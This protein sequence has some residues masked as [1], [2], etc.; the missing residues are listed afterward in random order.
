MVS[1]DVF[2]G[3]DARFTAFASLP[4]RF[5]ATWPWYLKSLL[6]ILYVYLSS[7][8]VCNELLD[9]WF[10]SIVLACCFLLAFLHH[11]PLL[12]SLLGSFPGLATAIWRMRFDVDLLRFPVFLCD[13]MMHNILYKLLVIIAAVQ[14]FWWLLLLIIKAGEWLDAFLTELTCT[15]RN[16]AISTG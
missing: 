14:L 12:S 1:K 15:Y 5:V 13:W 2:H 4:C 16:K 8:I 6:V 7:F 3:N 10:L 9:V 11:L